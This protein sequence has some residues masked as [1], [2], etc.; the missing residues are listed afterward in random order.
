MLNSGQKSSFKF[1]HE[2]HNPLYGTRITWNEQQFNKEPIV[3]TDSVKYAKRPTV[4]VA[5]AHL[6]THENHTSRLPRPTHIGTAH[7]IEQKLFKFCHVQISIFQ[8][9]AE[10][11][12]AVRHIWAR[13]Q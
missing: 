6:N 11:Q 8:N 4:S 10:K 1:L 5:T 9:I 12:N 7:L 2:A 13:S 3:I